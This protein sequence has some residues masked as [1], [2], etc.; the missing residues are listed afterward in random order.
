MSME[1]LFMKALRYEKMAAEAKDPAVK[2]EL[3]E[4]AR[5]LRAANDADN[6]RR[7]KVEDDCLYPW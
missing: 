6:V 4:V 7:Q 5:A 2:R 3:L 1:T